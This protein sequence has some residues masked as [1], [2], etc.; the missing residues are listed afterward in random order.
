[1]VSRPGVL[2][3]VRKVRFSSDLDRR[4]AGLFLH[5]RYR[6]VAAN[7]GPEWK[8]DMWPLAED[9]ASQRSSG[10]VKPMRR[11]LDSETRAAILSVKETYLGREDVHGID[12]Y[13]AVLDG[14]VST[15]GECD[16]WFVARGP[17]GLTDQQPRAR[18]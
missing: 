4:D 18:P 1:M 10:L 9:Y 14:G 15:A 5:H 2:S 3:S 12:V 13:R 17:T 7:D 16:T 8:I 11:G 6:D